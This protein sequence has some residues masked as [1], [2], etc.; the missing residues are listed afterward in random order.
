MR[1]SSRR[2]AMIGRLP[3]RNCSRPVRRIRA[4]NR[5]RKRRFRPHKFIKKNEL[6]SFGKNTA[7]TLV[8]P[9]SKLCDDS[10]PFFA[11]RGTTGSNRRGLP[12]SSDDECSIGKMD[13]QTD[14]LFRSSVA[15]RAPDSDPW[16][17]SK[18]E[19]LGCRPTPG[20]PK[21]EGSAKN[22]QPFSSSVEDE[23]PKASSL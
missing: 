22:P 2:K 20:C 17:I 19:V 5:L 10:R 18:Q 9:D 3:I 11:V 8:P 16:P 6:P 21:I 14:F 4:G 15:H 7:I 1:N 12:M 13:Q 23:H